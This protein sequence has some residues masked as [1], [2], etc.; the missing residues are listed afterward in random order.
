M[1]QPERGVSQTIR[2]ALAL[3]EYRDDREPAS[4]NPVGNEVWRLRND[5]F[6]GPGDA[7]GPSDGRVLREKGDAVQN[8]LRDVRGGGR[9]LPRD[10]LPKVNQMLDGASRPDNRHRRGG[11]RSRAL[12]QERSQAATSACS[13]PFLFVQLFEPGLNFIQLPALGLDKR[14]DSLG[15]EERFRPPRP[16]RERFQPL[17]GLDIQPNGKSGRHDVSACAELCTS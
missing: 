14:R 1:D 4:T 10:V 7:A 2:P 9:T 13:T 12:P 5:E 11:F 6:A 16:L 8:P 3:M 17:L 15:R